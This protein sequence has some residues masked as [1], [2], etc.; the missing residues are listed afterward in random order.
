MPKPYQT[1][2]KI[3][4]QYAFDRYSNE[5]LRIYGVMDR[6]LSKNGYLA[7]ARYSIADIATFPWIRLY[8]NQGIDLDD[9]RHV[10]RWLGAIDSRPAVQ[11]GLSV[12]A[13][14]RRR[15]KMDARSREMLYGTTQYKRRRAA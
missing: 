4:F 10:K 9:F 3:C 2:S 1:T 12:L 6:R 15:G 7:G 5:A 8:E 13:E 11:R 14:H